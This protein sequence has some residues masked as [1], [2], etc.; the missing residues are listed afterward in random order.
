MPPSFCADVAQLVEH[1][2]CNQVVG[3]SI[4][5]IGTTLYSWYNNPTQREKEAVMHHV[6]IDR[7]TMTIL[8]VGGYRALSVLSVVQER[9]NVTIAYADQ[10]KTYSAFSDAQ[11]RQLYKSI[12]GFPF[13]TANYF[14]L[15]QAIHALVMVMPKNVPD[16]DAL[17]TVATKKFGALP[18]PAKVK[19]SKPE[20]LITR[21]ERPV[22]SVTAG[23]TF[24]RPGEGTST[25]RVWA[26]CDELRSQTKDK[27]AL[28]Q[29]VLEAGRKAGINDSTISVQFG[30]WYV[31]EGSRTD[32]QTV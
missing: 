4:P 24:Q 6:A 18:K 27:K 16:E 5:L 9:P 14:A 2:T 26:L 10:N 1:L 30:K 7:D 31:T 17:E 20:R 29:L 13:T 25:G 23:S 22:Q 3:G 8:G 21:I 28:K 11:L 15:I 19:E 12:T 32:Q